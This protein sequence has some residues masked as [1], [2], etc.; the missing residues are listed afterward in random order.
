MVP[1]LSASPFRPIGPVLILLLP[2]VGGSVHADSIQSAVLTHIPLY[3]N[4]Q[5]T[6]GRA[7][8]SQE[9]NMLPG[10]QI[11]EDS[12]A[13]GLHLLLGW[14]CVWGLTSPCSP[15]GH[16]YSLSM[17]TSHPGTPSLASYSLQGQKPEVRF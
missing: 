5:S 10:I 2:L 9:G 16:S 1:S 13:P 17:S 6:R 4:L 8:G 14:A 7:W 15:T 12:R 3:D 11:P